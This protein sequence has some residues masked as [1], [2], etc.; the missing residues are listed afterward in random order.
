MDKKLRVI[1]RVVHKHSTN[2]VLTGSKKDTETIDGNLTPDSCGHALQ[3]FD[4]NSS[5]ADCLA[6]QSI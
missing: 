1:L 3:G 5:G 2:T 4:V 6:S